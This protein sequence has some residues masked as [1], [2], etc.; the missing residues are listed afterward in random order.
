[1]RPITVRQQFPYILKNKEVR[2]L[3]LITVQV[4]LLAIHYTGTYKQS[5]SGNQFTVDLDAV[6]FEGTNIVNVL[7]VLADTTIDEIQAKA[8]EH[9]M[10]YL[11][12]NLETIQNEQYAD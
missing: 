12:L 7:R 9:F 4:A 1:M 10:E 5:L 11:N 8:E 2:D 3:K 6:K